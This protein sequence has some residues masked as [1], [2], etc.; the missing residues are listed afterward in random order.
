MNGSA[1]GS[2]T[3]SPRLNSAD[4]I[5]PPLQRKRETCQ[6]LVAAAFE[7][8]P[9]ALRTAKA[10]DRTLSRTCDIWFF[11]LIRTMEHVRPMH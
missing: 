6:E 3:T 1:A 2:A 9:S 8:E 4:I 10:A 5:S 7:S 11:D